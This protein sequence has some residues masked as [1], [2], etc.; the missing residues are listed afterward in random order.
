M[1]R[2]IEHREIFEDAIAR[3]RIM[4]IRKDDESI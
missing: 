3:N 1:Q 2:F 4:I